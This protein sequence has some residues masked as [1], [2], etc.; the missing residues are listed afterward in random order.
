MTDKPCLNR[1]MA[2][3]MTP[4]FALTSFSLAIEALS[5]ANA[6]MEVDVYEVHLFGAIIGWP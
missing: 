6:L 2:F 5:V 1:K 4:G 3:L